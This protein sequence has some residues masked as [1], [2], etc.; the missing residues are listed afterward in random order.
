[1]RS[2]RLGERIVVGNGRLPFCQQSPAFEIN[3][4]VL[5]YSNFEVI[6]QVALK[7]L[8]IENQIG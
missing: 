8:D 3:S 7:R 2:F 5:V 4:S 6:S 1:M